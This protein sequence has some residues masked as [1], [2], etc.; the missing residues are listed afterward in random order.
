MYKHT[1]Y[2]FLGNKKYPEIY[3]L[4]IK[5]SFF[6]GVKVWTGLGKKLFY[7]KCQ[8]TKFIWGA[9]KPATANMMFSGTAQADWFRCTDPVT[10]GIV[11]IV[12]IRI[13]TGAGDRVH[14]PNHLESN[15][16]RSVHPGAWCHPGAQTRWLEDWETTGSFGTLSLTEGPRMKEPQ[17]F[18]CSWT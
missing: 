17:G 9:S 13:S 10:C 7:V 18:S 1:F 14:G 2:Y 5:T 16:S 15:I 11:N 6:P 3:I 4:Q 12:H 8:L